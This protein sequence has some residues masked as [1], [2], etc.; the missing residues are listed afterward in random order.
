[1]EPRE[2][3]ELLCSRHLDGELSPAEVERLESAMRADPE[4]RAFHA[5]MK[6]LHSTVALL[7]DSFKLPADF[8]DK[9]LAGVESEQAPAEAPVIQLPTRRWTPWVAAAAAV[10]TLGTL[11][12]AYVFNDPGAPN[13]T[14]AVAIHGPKGGGGAE[15]PKDPVKDPVVEFAKARVVA[16]SSGDMEVR[17]ASGKVTR[18]RRLDGE[19]SVPAEVRA[20][21]DSHA[22]L[23]LREGSI[24]L[25]PGARVSI[26][27][28]ADGLPDVAPMDG[29]I[30]LEGWGRSQVSSRV[31]KTPVKVD[32]GGLTLR[33]TP[34]GY[35]AQPSY[36]GAVVGDVVLST[37][38]C[39]VIGS[40]GVVVSD[41]E[42]APL[43]AWAID[44][45][46]DAIKFELRKLLGDKFEQ[47]DARQWQ[48]FDKLLKGVLAR[49]NE[50]AKHAYVLRLFIHHGF[51]EEA[52]AELVNAFARIADILGEG[53]TEEDIPV[54]ELRMLK[55]FERALQEDPEAMRQFKHMLRE[56]LEKMAERADRD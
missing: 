3:I 51:F 35:M 36:G 48:Q 31:D 8:R 18:E 14:P 43:D 27:A 37:G 46:A 47:I 12:T 15:S 56:M 9:V 10:L 29:D 41:C 5:R 33:S 2:E 19:I 44:G 53:T 21:A 32:R 22:T 23:Q 45:R 38:Q 4:L 30:Y 20:P 39:A 26:T 17:D 49:P 34:Q 52:E 13:T 11:V 50:R 54:N 25:K 24:V 42:A 1:M 28:D 16:V 7:A 6:T 40:D 55:E